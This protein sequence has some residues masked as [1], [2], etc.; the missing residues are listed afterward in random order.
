[1][2][3]HVAGS[4]PG[5]AS[6]SLDAPSLVELNAPPSPPAR[7]CAALVANYAP[8]GS[9]L[10]RLA[11]AGVDAFFGGANDLV[12]P[13]DGG[14]RVDGAP[15][16]GDLVGCFGAGGN[17]TAKEAVHHLNFF[18]QK[19]TVDFLAAALE[20]T[21]A[22]APP[23]DTE[24]LLPRRSARA[25]RG[26]PLPPEGPAPAP[27]QGSAAPPWP[28]ALC[29][30]SEGF[31]LVLVKPTRPGAP[32]QLLASYAG[33]RALEEL[34]TGGDEAGRR[35]QRIIAT[36]ERILSILEGKKSGELPND[37]ELL[38][39][40]DLLFTTLFAGEVRRLYYV[41]RSVERGRRLDVVFTSTLDWVAAKPWEFAYDRSRGAFLAT[42]DV[43]FVRNVVT[44][45]PAE[46]P[47]P[48]RDPLR[49]LVAI[50]QPLGLAPL[51]TDEEESLVR[52]GFSP[53]LDQGLAAIEVVRAVSADV[54]HQRVSSSPFDVLHF[55]GHGEW[56]DAARVGRLI[57]QDG[58]GAAQPVDSRTLREMLCHR[59]IS[60]VFLNAC[61]T[62][63]GGRADFNRGVAP[64]LVAGGIPAVVANQ[65]S[66]LDASD[67]AFARRFY[68]GLAS[69]ESLGDAAREARL[70]VK[71]AVSG[72]SMD[73]AVPVLFARDAGLP[74]DRLLANLVVAALADLR[75]PIGAHKRGPKSC[76]FH[77]QDER[78]VAVLAAPMHFDPACR[79][80][81][82][83]AVPKDLPAFE[84]MLK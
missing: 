76:P 10:L 65:Y 29:T 82:K 60:L 4:L 74:E 6:M 81:L 44:A 39:Y 25:P 52:R 69:G 73:L 11:D 78:D 24:A 22:E 58:T 38:T 2:A 57:F 40:G 28:R 51:S 80:R 19:E 41:A 35:M 72:E 13:T 17:L 21:P 8:E 16:A 43:N 59:G 7:S 34:P 83:K 64:A 9:L 55:I 30:G 42:E 46:E 53:L 77:F 75:G 37:A 62:G 23:L 47:A 12:V 32:A 50:A 54:L 14:Y 79:K 18:A 3:H 36:H 20:G 26:A 67:T 48:R 15:L 27:A 71:T 84:A 61:D 31:Q 1:M 66:V 63:R 70:A 56:D 33:A 68:E 49:I 45:V 5:L